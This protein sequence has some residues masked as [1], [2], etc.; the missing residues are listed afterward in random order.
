MNSNT[1]VIH[2]KKKRRTLRIVIVSIILLLIIARFILPYVILKVVNKKLAAIENYYGHVEDIDLALIRGAYQINDLLLTKVDSVTHQRDTTPF[3]KTPQIDLSV[4]WKSIFKGR[5][6]GEIIIESPVLNFVQGKHKGEDVK[7]DTTDFQDVLKTLMPL[8]INHFQ[9]NNGQIHF[10]D[11]NSSPK[12]DVPL[13]NIQVTADNLSNVNDSNKVLPSA[14]KATGDVYGGNFNMNVKLNPLE[15]KPTFDLNAGINNVDMLKLN[16]FFEAYGNFKVEKGNFGLYTE[17]AAKEGAFKG[18]VKPLLKDVDI[19]KEGTFGEIVWANVVGG[20]KWILENH[21]KEQVATKLP[22]EGRFDKPDTGLWTAISYIL[23]NAF[24][25]AL[26]PSVDN[27][28]DLGKV[29]QADE[30]KTFLQKVFGK[31]DKDGKEKEHKKKEHK[32]KTELKKTS[33]R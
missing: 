8:T 24:V 2:P 32:D 27:D 28:I 33:K 3:F 15:K 19:A 26:Q 6:V 14:I 21:K 1:T 13:K 30:K 9:I 7:Q 5:I 20:V 4:E 16:D 12:I 29:E 22:V 11:P 18:Y 17:F 31:K 10:I 25:L 23:K